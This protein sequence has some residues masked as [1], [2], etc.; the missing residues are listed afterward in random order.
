MLC[1]WKKVIGRKPTEQN[2]IKLWTELDF[3][4][5]V[6]VN[7]SASRYSLPIQFQVD[8]DP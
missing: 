7:T 6:V 1:I 5:S 4:Q 2:S 3:K 8:Y